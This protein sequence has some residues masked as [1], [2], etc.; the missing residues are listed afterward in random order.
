MSR[1]CQRRSGT[2]DG[3]RCLPPFDGARQEQ[4]FDAVR[5]SRGGIA[6]GVVR[7]DAEREAR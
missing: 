1:E 2:C 6:K 7:V 3:Q 5:E 4:G